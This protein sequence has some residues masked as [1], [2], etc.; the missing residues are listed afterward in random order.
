MA[1]AQTA[2][3]ALEQLARELDIGMV[4]GPLQPPQNGRLFLG[5]RSLADLLLPIW[6]DRLVAILIASGGQSHAHVRSG[7]AS[8]GDDALARLETAAQQS[9]GHVYR[10]RLAQLTP[11]T[12]L[13]RFGN[14]NPSDERLPSTSQYGWSDNLDNAETAALGTSPTLAAAR[15][16]G[17]PAA[18]AEEPVLFLDRQPIYYLMMQE[19]AGRNVTMLIGALPDR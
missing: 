8:L 17:W 15:A 12:W 14:S 1:Q 18:F 16:T 11:E 9:S 10:G 4:S 5:D 2:F 3:D 6:S 19:D 13:Q 7:R